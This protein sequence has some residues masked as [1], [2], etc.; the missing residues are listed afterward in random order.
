[1]VAASAYFNFRISTSN[2]RWSNLCNNYC[3]IFKQIYSL[4]WT[5]SAL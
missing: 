4:D 2:C 5:W 3:Y 1:L